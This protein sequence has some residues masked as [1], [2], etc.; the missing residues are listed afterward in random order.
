MLL[1][2]VFFDHDDGGGFKDVG[3]DI[4]LGFDI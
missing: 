3:A 2:S 1:R 4:V